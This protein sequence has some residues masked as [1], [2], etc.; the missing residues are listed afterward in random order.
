MPSGF[1]LGEGR[2][3]RLKNWDVN[4]TE[5]IHILIHVEQSGVRDLALLKLQ[6]H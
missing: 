6:E 4:G 3:K 2:R 5:I 1:L